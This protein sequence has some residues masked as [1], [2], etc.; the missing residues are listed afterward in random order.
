M[1]ITKLPSNLSVNKMNLEYL[2]LG[3]D[4]MVNV[5]IITQWYIA[6]DMII[7]E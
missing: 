6:T 4:T 7:D 5:R 1:K 2:K 3:C